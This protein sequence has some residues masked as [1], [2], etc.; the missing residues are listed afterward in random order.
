MLNIRSGVRNKILNFF[1]LNEASRVYINELARQIQADPKNV[2]RMLVQLEREGILASEFKGKERYFFSRKTSPLYKGFKEIFLRTAG[3]ET[4]LTQALANVPNLKEA[5]LF[6][7][8]AEK[9]H[10][11]DSDIDILLVGEHSPLAAEKVLY[12][13][14]KQIGR[15]ISAVNMKAVEFKKRRTHGDQFIDTVFGGKV[16]K[17]V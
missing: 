12:G 17:L 3:I 9:R 2:Y 7:S 8:Y 13:I 11:P 4:M 14:Q 10:G 15:E 16:V 1:F 6:G 5:Y